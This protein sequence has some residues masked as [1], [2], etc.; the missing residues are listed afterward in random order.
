MEGERV[1]RQAL[2]LAEKQYAPPSPQVAA[3]LHNL[4]EFSV[5]TGKLEEAEALYVRSLLL[6]ERIYGPSDGAVGP[7]LAGLARC[8][9]ARGK[10]VDAEKAYVRS[11]ALAQKTLGATGEVAGA[12]QKELA[13]LRSSSPTSEA[14]RLFQAAVELDKQARYPE[15][16]RFFEQVVQLRPDYRP[17]HEY[18]ALIAEFEQDDSRAEAEH[19]KAINLE[20]RQAEKTASPYRNYAVFL[21]KQPARIEEALKMLNIAVAKE[22]DSSQTQYELG[23][24]LLQAGRFSESEAALT[25][26][27]SLSPLIPRAHYFLGQLYQ[28]IQQ[29]AK[30][31]EQFARFKT[32]ES[33]ARQPPASPR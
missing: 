13:A 14:D 9:S 6:A 3:S 33:A 32:A 21:A 12:L 10:K 15:A 26:S 23:R 19:L 29:P 4:A 7:V 31:R 18:L 17:A 25:R 1:A 20:R 5:R 30:A 24:V 28:Q 27:L 2:T 8:Y 22:P 16:R 11:I